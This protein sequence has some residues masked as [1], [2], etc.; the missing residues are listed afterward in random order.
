[1][2]W[3]KNADLDMSDVEDDRGQSGSRGGGGFSFPGGGIPL[4]KG[5]GI[6]TMI[7]VALAAFLLPKLLG[8]GGGFNIN[9]GALPGQTPEAQ[10]NTKIDGAPQDATTSGQPTDEQARFAVWV[11]NDTQRTWQK[12]FQGADKP[13][14]PAHMRLYTDATQ[15]GCGLGQAA[16]GP[17]Y[18]PADKT[19]YLDLN[20]YS[21]LAKEFDAPGDFAQAYV[22]A[23]EMGHH[24]QNEIG[25]SDQV[26]RMQRQDPDNALNLSVRL[27]L[28]ADCLAGVWAHS[29]YEQNTEDRGLSEGDID[30]GIRAARS[31]GDDTIQERTTGQINPDS[32]T[33]G[34]ADQRV[35][36]FRVGFD[37][38]ISDKC[39]TFRPK[40]V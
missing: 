25:I 1:M 34:S 22:V 39:D 2:K 35:H 4:P 8:G 10:S 37:S 16:M 11:F 30:E 7:L 26:T 36:W 38:G 6:L 3:D 9:S 12:E 27:E 40:T 15:T 32:W 31:V 19:V 28:Q 13:Y 29:V 18:C 23:H 21:Q 5:G 17:F 20:F 33:H 14:S 24:V